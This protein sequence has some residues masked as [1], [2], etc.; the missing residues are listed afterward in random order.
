ADESDGSGVDGP[1]ADGPVADGAD[2]EAGW[3]APEYL[4]AV[5]ALRASR[6]PDY[7][8]ALRALAGARRDRVEQRRLEELLGRLRAAAPGLAEAWQRTGGQTFAPGT[9]RFQHLG[10]VLAALPDA[11]TLDVLLLLGADHLDPGYLAVA[12]A[13]PRLL[14]ASSAGSV[15]SGSVVSSA[16][17]PSVPSGQPGALAG[18]LGVDGETVSAMLRRAGVPVITATD[19]SAPPNGGPKVVAYR[20]KGAPALPAV[21][22]FRVHVSET[23]SD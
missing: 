18:R 6:L 12:A 8:E 11:D 20:P 1:G 14:V 19:R 21:H 10:E 23:P 2:R 7:L 13:A 16:G 5:R 3:P 9:V 4:A 15:V 22:P 17:G